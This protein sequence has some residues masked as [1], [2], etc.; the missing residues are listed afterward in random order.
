VLLV[1]N[2]TGADTGSLDFGEVCKNE[3][4]PE[5]EKR[6]SDRPTVKTLAVQKLEN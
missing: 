2:Q 5:G 1:E 3:N 6:A 4:D